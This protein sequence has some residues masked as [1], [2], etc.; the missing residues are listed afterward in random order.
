MAIVYLN[1]GSN[2]GDKLSLIKRA[3]DEIGNIF[4]YY[5]ISEFVE[6]E[7]WGFDSTNSFLNVGVCFK[8][9]LEPEEVLD[10]LQKIERSISEV[11]HRDSEGNYADREIDIDIMAIDEI[12][13]DSPRLRLPHPH[14]LERDFFIKPLKELNPGW[15]HP[16]QDGFVDTAGVEVCG[17]GVEEV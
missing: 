8:S 16:Y 17:S 10:R 1:I 3:I 15:K 12:I 7:P 13:Y 14:L 5:C 11:N 9:F 2:L 4:G 6:S